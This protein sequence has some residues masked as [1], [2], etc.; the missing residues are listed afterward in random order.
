MK[1]P[2]VDFVKRYAESDISRFHMPGHKGKVHLGCE[3]LDITEIDGADVLYSAC[4]I[5]E[6][7]EEY[8]SSLFHSAHTFYSAEGSSLVIKAMLG[9]IKST[10]KDGERPIILAARNVHKAF[11]YACALL[12]LDVEWLFPK[13]FTHLCT[14]NITKEDVKNAICRMPRKPD[15]VYL[16]SPDYLG[17]VQDIRGISEVCR[18]YDIPLLVDNAHGAYLAFLEE[19]LHPL[20]LGASMCSDSAHKTL[21]VLTGGA[22]LHIAKDAPKTFL[23]QARTMLSLFAST[24]PSYLILQSL[25]L[26]NAY[27]ANG[28]GKKLADCIEKVESIKKM[29]DEKGIFYEKSEPLKL[30]LN[31]RQCGY[32]G[33]EIAEYLRERKMEIEFSDPDFAVLMFTPENDEKDFTR[34]ENALASL[35]KREPFREE[36]PLPIPNVQTALSVRDAV[37]SPKKTVPVEDAVGKVCASPLV[38]CPPAVPIVMSGEVITKEAIAWFAHYET[39]LVEIVDGL[40]NDMILK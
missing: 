38:S 39:A 15:A 20:A 3:A 22:Y 6:K 36:K 14:C 37:F 1:T 30:V 17:Q 13:H 10:K 2:I 19:N 32:T 24:S 18:A 25:D 33:E 40:S 7:S 12:D 31:A 16:T 35:P 11:I 28:Y 26:C 9:I 34:L 21:P 27:L 29:L 5:I 4:G 23:S 8:T